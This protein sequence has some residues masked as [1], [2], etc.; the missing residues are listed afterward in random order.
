MKVNFKHFAE[1]EKG[2]SFL[3]FTERNSSFS[4]N[5]ESYYFKHPQ[6]MDIN[7]FFYKK[8]TYGTIP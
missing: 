3:F 7:H 2:I 1:V 6:T 5:L 8:K 4:V